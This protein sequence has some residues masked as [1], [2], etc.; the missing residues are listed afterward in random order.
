MAIIPKGNEPANIK[1]RLDILFPKLDGAYPDK[2]IRSLNKEH[3]KWG[4]TVTELYRALGYPDSES[5]L[6]AYGYTVERAAGGRPT[7]DHMA[8]IEELKKRYPDGTTFAK[9]GELQDANPDLANKFKTLA[10]KSKDLFGMSLA[11]YFKSIGLLGGSDH[12][13]QLDE[14][15][16]ELKRRYPI[17]STLPTTLA[18]LKEDNADLM[19]SRLVYIKDFF[20]SDPKEY[21]VNAGLIKEIDPASELE[22]IVATIR[23]R[24]AGK[25][26]PGTLDQL[27]NENSDLPFSAAAK[28]TEEVFGM[29]LATYL[30]KEKIID[31]E[32]RQLQ[33][34]EKAATNKPPK[35]VLE[36]KG[37]VFAATALEDFEKKRIEKT[38]TAR[39]GIYRT[40]VSKNTDYLIINPNMEYPS[41]KY[42]T[43]KD[44]ISKGV[45]IQIYSYAEFFKEVHLRGDKDLI[46]EE[47]LVNN[48]VLQKY[49]GK[50]P[51][52][53]IPDNIIEIGNRAFKECDHI[54]SVTIPSS[55]KTI[56]NNA[57]QYCSNLETVT[58]CGENLYSIGNSAFYGCVSLKEITL[59]NSVTE[60]G[61]RIFVGCS[62]LRS[63]ML[64][65]NLQHIPYRTFRFL[66]GE[67][68]FYCPFTDI[69]I[70]DSV[71]EIDADAFAGCTSLKRITIPSNIKRIEESAFS[72]CSA[73]T[74]FKVDENNQS[75][76]S[77]AQ[78]A[79]FTKSKTTL[80]QVPAGKTGT[81]LVS[82][83][84]CKIETYALHNCDRLQNVVFLGDMPLFKK[85][86][87]SS[88][89]GGIEHWEDCY[90]NFPYN[91]ITAYYP[92]NNPSWKN[93]ELLDF[94]GDVTWVP[95]DDFNS[96]KQSLRLSDNFNDFR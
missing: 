21:L 53:S 37:R 6:T 62:S 60:I 95:Y 45:N 31:L 24:Y 29:S 28:W 86:K 25:L 39:G 89:E 9:I 7:N 72:G 70:P 23:E 52:V 41:P 84:V 43:A 27:K 78:G 90:Y 30:K 56:G 48:G 33:A 11:D 67:D 61:E 75:Y 8:V 42:L 34:A 38:V 14:L 82:N 54:L 10:N 91:S 3:R 96:L 18:Q 55:V 73:L 15:L 68:V 5:F 80:I 50:N 44:W 65:N 47:F 49:T 12:K 85:V 26:M 93:I 94:Y 79:L 88:I 13:K 40:S 17:G 16:A 22:I 4:E 87:I 92:K 66:V 77:D 36:F 63:V 76:S 58:F 69:I 83:S 74:E 35:G 19:V 46:T 64:S 32:S 71:T 59:P 2:V 57:F 51:N 81:Y 1:K 20:G